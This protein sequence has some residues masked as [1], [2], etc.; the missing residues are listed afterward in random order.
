MRSKEIYSMQNL[1]QKEV[2]L[3]LKT[4]HKL[5]GVR[6]LEQVKVP[7]ELLKLHPIEWM[8]LSQMLDAVMW[9]KEDKT[10]H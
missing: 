1:T 4:I 6:Q 5:E 7:K 9:E 8:V 2:E 10:H 3:A